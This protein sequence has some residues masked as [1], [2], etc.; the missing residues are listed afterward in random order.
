MSELHQGRRPRDLGLVAFLE[1]LGR[2]LPFLDE[3]V[4]GGSLSSPDPTEDGRLSERASTSASESSANGSRS[5][6]SPVCVRL[7]G[8]SLHLRHF[9]FGSD[10][11]WG[12]ISPSL[13]AAGGGGDLGVSAAFFLRVLILVAG[14]AGLS[15][16]P[17]TSMTSSASGGTPYFESRLDMG[18]PCFFFFMVIALFSICWTYRWALTPTPLCQTSLK[19]I[20]EKWYRSIQKY[21]FHTIHCYVLAETRNKTGPRSYREGLIL[22]PHLL[23]II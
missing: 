11:R 23:S 9:S 18:R 10:F 12:R 6:F 5:F 8:G 22:K 13:F 1:E 2:P 15:G 20:K 21:I 19:E 17:S 16:G 14:L 7:V 3:G 4:A